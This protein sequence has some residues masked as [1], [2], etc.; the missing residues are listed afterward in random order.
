MSTRSNWS[1]CFLLSCVSLLIIPV[2]WCIRYW[3]KGTE[4]SHYTVTLCISP[5]TSGS[6]LPYVSR[7]FLNCV[8]IIKCLSS[9]LLSWW[10]A[11]LSLV[12]LVAYSL[13]WDWSNYFDG[14][15]FFLV[16]IF[17]IFTFKLCIF[18]CL[19][20]VSCKQQTTVFF[21]I[22]PDFFVFN[23]IFSPFTFGVIIDI[24]SLKPFIS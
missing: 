9:F 10:K 23:W 13:P 11:I 6:F 4:I 18:C 17:P 2:C 21:L 8:Q 3:D 5:F 14:L 19:K 16:D 7:L 20:W 1:S 12:A 24:F 22:Q 15:F